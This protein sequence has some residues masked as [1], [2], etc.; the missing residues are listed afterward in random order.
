MHCAA[1]LGRSCAGCG[2]ALPEGARFCPVCAH[3][4]GEAP[5]VEAPVARDP[6]SYTPPHLA[7]RIL[8]ARSALE[9]ERKHVTVLFLDVAGYT[10]LAER[11]DPEQMHALMDRCFQI[12]LAEVHR[13]EGTVNQFTGD[14]VMALFGAP[15]ALEDAPRRA[16]S[17]ALGIQRALAPLRDEVRARLGS[18][19]QVRIGL[20]SGPVVVGRIGDDLRMDYTA[21]GDTT[22]LAARLQQGAEPGS[23]SISETTARLAAGYFDLRDLGEQRVK[24]RAEPVRTFAVLG[25]RR[26][27]DRIEVAAEAGLTP[28]VGR[29]R[30]LAELMEA[31]ASAGEGRGQVSFVV[32]EAG[33]GKS[34][35]LLELRR[36]L[37]GVPCIWLEGRCTSFGRDTAF[38]PIADLFRRRFGIEDRDDD[39]TAL[40]KLERAEA[41]RGGELA[42]TLP[43][44]R[45]LLSLPAGD[46]RLAE[47]DPGTRRSET[48]RALH[49]R[50]LRAAER[51]PLVLVV[52]DVHWIDAAS[53]E[54]LG[55]L[56]ESVPAMRALLVLTHR[57]GYRQPFGDRSYHRRIAV[58]A[59]SETDVTAMAGSIFEARQLPEPLRQLIARKAEGNPFFVEEL[60]ASLLEEGAL[61]R[62]DSRI[63]LVGDPEA[64]SVPD[65]IQDV[66]MARIDRLDDEPKRAIQVASVIGRE[67]AFRLLDR[68][69]DAG[70]RLQQ[71][72]DELRRLELIYQ[73]AIHPELAYV[74]KHALTQEVAYESVLRE[75]RRALHH[76]VG[77]AIE[78]LYRDRLVE[79]YEALAHHFARAE[80]WKRALDYHERAAEKSLDAYANQAA[81]E[82]ARRALEIAD[83]LG[84][85]VAA[86]RRRRLAELLAQAC[87]QR[88]EFGQAGEAWLRAADHAEDEGGRAQRLAWASYCLHWAHDYERASEIIRRARALAAS[89]GGAAEQVMA[90]VVD[91][92]REVT[93]RGPER[94]EADAW[95]EMLRRAEGNEAVQGWAQL[96]IGEVLEWCG[97]YPRAAEMQEGAIAVARHLRIPDLLIPSTW[98]LAKAKCCLGRYGEAMGLLSEGIDLA[99]RVGGRA[100]LTR[101]LNTMGWCHA[102]FGDHARA[103]DYNARS[104]ALATELVEL[105]L[106]PGAPELYGNAAINLAGNHIALGTPGA[107][108]D[109]LAS[110]QASLAHDDDPWMRWRYSLHLWEALGRLALARGEPGA[111]RPWALRALEG[112][113]RHHV[114]KV[115]A[116]ARELLGRVDVFEDRRDA[117]R[118]ELEAALALAR[119][120]G[121]PPVQWRSQ[122]LLGELA[123]RDGRA[124]EADRHAH[125]ARHLAET[126]AAAIPDAS[127]RAPLRALAEALASD[128]LTA[129][130]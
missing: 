2:A 27:R 33:I 65:R 81:A 20:H 70:T 116:R 1:P 34:R 35:L 59:L 96:H 85:E 10:A 120:I 48:V 40:G 29:A 56:A 123:R 75:R 110:V 32:G 62:V 14:G 126:L 104:V 39:E 3:P 21:V 125:E 121:Y 128:P 41:E 23:I 83:R 71:V 46:P 44:L 122:A 55:F 109:A 66:L 107:A 103:A 12:V 31:F 52:E 90:D 101:L 6:R 9:G 111:A 24:G 76:L 117:G 16:I 17:A 36:R 57:P 77:M 28:M 102:E 113:Q 95:T 67:F 119:R 7:E 4:A 114:L 78:E 50:F 51:E 88:S 99:E 87:F 54:M 53:E 115:E 73:K 127:R 129:L 91:G 74:F 108:E 60:T 84:E 94:F 15:L 61:C 93:T 43:F 22:N 97:D 118:Q 5:Q 45:Q 49:A 42:W 72:V 11:A 38:A 105:G 112:A 18:D 37:E 26:A 68:I 89:S 19:F 80:D 64:L 92:F 86:E 106:V 58:Q 98:F 82:H 79:H 63:E 130:R 69:S 47:M 13:T 30:E 25:E 100:F 124:A 8:T